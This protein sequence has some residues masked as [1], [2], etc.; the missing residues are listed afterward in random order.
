MQEQER[1]QQELQKKLQQYELLEGN[2][3][4]PSVFEPVAD[5]EEDLMDVDLDGGKRKRRRFT[6]RLRQKYNHT[7]SNKTFKKK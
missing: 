7:K 1:L 3:H 5:E 2:S 6:R 4:D